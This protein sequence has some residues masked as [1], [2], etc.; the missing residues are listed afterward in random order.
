MKN[1]KTTR[2]EIR[3]TPEEKELLK[4]YAAKRNQTVSEL[5]RYYCKDILDGTQT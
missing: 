5:I 4:E 3:M 2:I 1:P